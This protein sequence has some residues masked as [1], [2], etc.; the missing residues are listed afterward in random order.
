MPAGALLGVVREAAGPLLRDAAVADRYEG[1]PLP[2]GRVSLTLSLR[3]QAQ[4]RTLLGDEVDRAMQDVGARLRAA[5]H[6]IRG[7]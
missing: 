5:G 7:E 2:A 1:A 6:E 4:E 3:F